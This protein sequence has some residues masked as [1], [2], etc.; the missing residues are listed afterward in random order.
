[1]RLASSLVCPFEMSE[2]ALKGDKHVKLCALLS[3]CLAAQLQECNKWIF[4]FSSIG[5]DQVQRS[6]GMKGVCKE[7]AKVRQVTARAE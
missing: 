1:M 3:Q 5:I 4:G 2:H 6:K 7:S